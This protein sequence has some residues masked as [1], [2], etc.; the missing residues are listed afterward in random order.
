VSYE[1]GRSEAIRNI[2]TLQHGDTLVYK[3]GCSDARFHNVVPDRVLAT[4]GKLLYRHIG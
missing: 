1:E 4:A 3:Y 2:M